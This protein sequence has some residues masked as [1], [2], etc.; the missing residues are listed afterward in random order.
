MSWP[1]EVTVVE[2][3]A[4]SSH[5]HAAAGSAP[6][7]TGGG[8]ARAP[9][10]WSGA[11]LPGSSRRGPFRPPGPQQPG[12]EPSWLSGAGL[13]R[14]PGQTRAQGGRGGRCVAGRGA[15]EASGRRAGVGRGRAGRG[16][17]GERRRVVGLPPSPG[18]GAYF[19]HVYTVQVSWAICFALARFPCGFHAVS[20][21]PGAAAARGRSAGR[22]SVLCSKKTTPG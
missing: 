12:G 6:A 9:C 1:W 19:F 4:G 11:G 21:P 15:G 14:H 16:G 13:Q 5:L 3:A 7:S 2:A 8:S 20:K 17:E 10:R 22:S 18:G